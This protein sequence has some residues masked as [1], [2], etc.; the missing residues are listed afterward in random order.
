MEAIREFKDIRHAVSGGSHQYGVMVSYVAGLAAEA[1]AKPVQ[2][3]GTK[4]GLTSSEGNRL[5]W[6]QPRALHLAY[7]YMLGTAYRSVE[8]TARPLKVTCGQIGV[9]YLPWVV[10]TIASLHG[11]PTTEEDVKTWMSEPEPEVHLQKRLAHEA[12]GAERRAAGRSEASEK[13][14]QLRAEAAARKLAQQHP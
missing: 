2:E 3:D 10:A 11:V 6:F 13:H 12:R 14:L 7:N 5:Q 8:P 1:V 4:L 9:V